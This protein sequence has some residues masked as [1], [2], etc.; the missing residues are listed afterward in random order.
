MAEVKR[1]PVVLMHNPKGGVGKT[2]LSINL[3]LAMSQLPAMEGKRIALMDFDLWGANLSTVVCGF[4]L[5][6]VRYRNI[7]RWKSMGTESL[8]QAGLDKLLFKGPGNV[9]V[10]A[11]P[12]NF[13]EGHGFC[14]READHILKIAE[15]YHDAVIIDGGPGITDAVDMALH[16]ATH[17][18]AVTNPEG[19]SLSQLAKIINALDCPEDFALD[20]DDTVDIHLLRS[21]MKERMEKLYVVVNHTRTAGKYAL[22]NREI[23]ET[24]GKSIYAEI[25]FSEHVLEALHGKGHYQAIDIDAKGAFSKSLRI[26][27]AGICGLDTEELGHAENTGKRKGAGI[28]GL[29]RRSRV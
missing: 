4:P 14:H 28:K 2:T 10:A 15:A 23:E 26:L 25:P 7:T 18:L 17:I 29:F 27:A 8:G 12:F 24:L 11:A 22:E 1:K 6:E 5:D 9:R 3:S 16:H 13:A 19:Q 21:A 20:L